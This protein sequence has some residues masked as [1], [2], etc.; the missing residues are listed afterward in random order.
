MLTPSSSS[1]PAA[2]R[3]GPVRRFAG[4]RRGVAFIEFAFIA[5]I[6][7][8]LF[9]GTVEFSQAITAD[10]RVTKIASSV[11]DLIARVQSITT[12]EVDDIFGIG[13]VL[14]QPFDTT[15]LSITAFNVCAASASEN[16]QALYWSRWNNQGTQASAPMPLPTGIIEK[17]GEVVAV[18]VNYEYPSTIT[19]WL[20]NWSDHASPGAGNLTLTLSETF[21]VKPRLGSTQLTGTTKPAACN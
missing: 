18:T 3:P 6:M 19:G 20:F 17:G 10:R 7:M 16:T 12:G 2:R 9:F 13:T 5:P 15:E 14:L 11:A 4:D 1:R 8:L 21:Y